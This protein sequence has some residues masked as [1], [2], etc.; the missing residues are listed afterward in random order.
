[1]QAVA[2]FNATAERTAAD[3]GTLGATAVGGG[4]AGT[5]FAAQCTSAGL[6]V[7]SALATS[8]ATLQTA[9]GTQN[10][11]VMNTDTQNQLLIAYGPPAANVRY[12]LTFAS[13]LTSMRAFQSS[14]RIAV[15]NSI[16]TVASAVS[17]AVTDSDVA[18]ASIGAVFVSTASK[19][20]PEEYTSYWTRFRNAVWYPILRLVFGDS[21][22]RNVAVTSSWDVK[23]KVVPVPV[24]VDAVATSAYGLAGGVVVMQIVFAAIQKAPK[25]KEKVEGEE[26]KH[27][28]F[29]GAKG[30]LHGGDDESGGAVVV[31]HE[32]D[33]HH[34]F[35]RRTNKA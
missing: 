32:M 29:F 31:V 14:Y 15:L 7:Q 33:P 21:M 16:S 22:R 9:A 30:D 1:V 18:G 6:G 24:I 12:D 10:A 34:A 13:A 20:T 8:Q 3:C 19:Y 27:S 2:R 4:S 11:L 5:T 17:A 28:V 25:K 23:G 26:E 35:R